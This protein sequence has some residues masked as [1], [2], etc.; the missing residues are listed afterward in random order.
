MPCADVEPNDRPEQS[1]LLTTINRSCIGSFQSE[2][3]GK[4][5]YYEVQLNS[6]QHIIV[7]LTGIP[8]EANYDIALIRQDSPTLF[9]AVAVSANSGQANEHIDYVADSN[10]RYFVRVRAIAKST[11]ANNAYILR[12]AIP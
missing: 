7:D 5:D 3:V 6:G 1:H 4:D 11:S 8:S 9:L 2:Q 10:K 12:V